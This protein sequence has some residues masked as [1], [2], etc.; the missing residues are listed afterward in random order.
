MDEGASV[1]TLPPPLELLDGTGQAVRLGNKL[2]QGGEGSVYEVVGS[3]AIVAKIY[4]RP[5]TPSLADK[6][7]VMAALRTDQIDKLTAWP[8]GLLSSRA[9]APLGLTMPRIAGYKDIH[10]LYSPKS[11]RAEFSNAD[12]RFLV[13]AA[14]NLAR[15]FAT[16][17]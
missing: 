11:R 17:H 16:V 6:I 14:T 9:G 4:H 3:A 10:Q 15:A 1:S 5:P 8:I 12:W 2:G 13:R 7:R